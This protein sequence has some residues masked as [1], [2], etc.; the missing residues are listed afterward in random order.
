MSAT[1]EMAK[2]YFPRLWSKARLK[3]LVQADRLTA[4]EYKE[5]TGE[6]V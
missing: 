3:A 5:I 6:E 4:E 2:K 1:Y